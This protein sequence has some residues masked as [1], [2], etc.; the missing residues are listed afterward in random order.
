MFKQFVDD[1]CKKTRS[2]IPSSCPHS[3]VY[4]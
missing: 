3:H 4:K 2:V 1:D